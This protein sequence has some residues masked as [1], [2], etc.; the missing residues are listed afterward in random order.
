MRKLYKKRP[1]YFVTAVQLDLDFEGFEYQK[2]GGKQK[3]KAGDWLINNGGDIYTVD[4]R[5]FTDN[6][7]LIS[8]GVYNK[9]EEIWAEVAVE[10]GSIKTLEGSTDYKADDYLVFDQKEGGDGYAIKKQIFESMY[11]V[12]EKSQRISKTCGSA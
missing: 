11:E 2:W 12:I 4:K 6:Y 10:N 8:P 1:K 7:Q 3:C 9:V 5:Y